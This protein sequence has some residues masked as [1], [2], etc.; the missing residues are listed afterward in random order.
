LSAV[1]P[2]TGAAAE[3]DEALGGASRKRTVQVRG[4]TIE[5]SPMTVRRIRDFLP[6]AR[7]L[8]AT[9]NGLLEQVVKTRS[10]DEL[11][12]AQ[13][14]MTLIEQHGEH[15]VKATAAAVGREAAWI[16]DAMPDELLELVTAVVSVNLDFFVRR[17]IPNG[18]ASVRDLGATLRL[19]GVGRTASKRSSAADID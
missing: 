19:L 5:V 9:V 12:K 3:I 6:H 18:E 10:L 11:L 15:V 1:A 4:E 8:M 14:L 13:T 16:D 2:L 17:L 7:P